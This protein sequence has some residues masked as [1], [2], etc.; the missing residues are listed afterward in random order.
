VYREGGSK[1]NSVCVR[2]GVRVKGSG[3]PEG[4]GVWEKEGRGWYWESSAKGT[5]IG[6]CNLNIATVVDH[7][8]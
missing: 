2:A 8:F 6:N 7:S 1:V 3:G 4:I 5:A